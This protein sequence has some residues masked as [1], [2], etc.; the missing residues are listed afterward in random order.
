MVF[1]VYHDD[2]PIGNTYPVPLNLLQ[3]C[4]DNGLKIALG[5]ASKNAMTI[6]N[7]T[8]LTPYFDVI[9]DGTPNN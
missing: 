6:L 2:G 5:S 9:I 7:N 1:P 3:E 8:G 4:R